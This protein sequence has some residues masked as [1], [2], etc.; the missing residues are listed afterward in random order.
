MTPSRKHTQ[1]GATV[2]EFTLSL[3]VLIPLLIG[4]YV[5]GF[6][7]VRNQQ[8]DQITRDLAHMYS[9][10]VDF[11]QSGAATEAATLAN[12]FGLTSTGTSVV[13]FSTVTLETAAACNAATGSNN[14]TN[15][16]KPVFT[17]QVAIGNTTANSSAYGTP[18]SNGVLPATS[19]VS[20][21]YS[22]NVSS[23]AQATNTWAVAYNFGTV[24]TLTSGQ[25][26]YMV[27]MFNNTPDLNVPGL[28]GS[29]QVY[30]RAIF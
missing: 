2:L 15:L 25:F 7:L 20:N 22:T 29:P 18:V 12:Q 11:T 5:F 16:N 26:A 24:I 23:S 13:I 21:D 30:S 9:R 1:S 27:E 19:G 8:T 4:V 3:S 6:R 28:T 17:Q 14:C 10:G